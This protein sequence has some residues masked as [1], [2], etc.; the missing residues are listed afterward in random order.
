MFL[1]NRFDESKRRV[2]NV[3]KV[4]T[5]AGL[6]VVI[7]TIGC[8]GGPTIVETDVP[9]AQARLMAINFAYT[10]F[11]QERGRPPKNEAEL[12]QTL[13]EENQ[14]ETLLSPV[15]GEP[16]VICYGVDK[17]GPLD[18]AKTTPVLAY[19]QNGDG[20]RWVLTV[21][22]AIYQLDETEY[23]EA[24]LPPGHTVQ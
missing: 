14:E 9:E 6:L 16:F 7:A 12:R 17:F 10:Q 19:E 18:W 15:D 4:F 2:T 5:L 23:Q 13:A 20:S 24:S 1:R 8:G 21:P 22:G 3:S 11:L